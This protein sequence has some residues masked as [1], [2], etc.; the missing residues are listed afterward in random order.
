MNARSYLNAFNSIMDNLE[1][2]DLS[3][4]VIDYDDAVIDVIALIRKQHDQG[5]KVIFIGNGG[6]ASIAS[7]MAIDFWRNAGV[8]ALTFNDGSLLT[9]ISNDFGYPEVF[10]KPISCFADEGD[11]LV[12]I[13]SSGKS[14]NI[15]NAVKAAHDL[16]AHVITFSGFAPINPLRKLGEYNF[17]VPSNSF[18]YVEV[19]HQLILHTIVDIMMAT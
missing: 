19:A 16:K 2:T 5:K 9:C 17:Y 13:S 3:A 18:G 1:I 7:H 6:S 8:R 10:A 4:Q 11:I 15:L 14:E 12:T